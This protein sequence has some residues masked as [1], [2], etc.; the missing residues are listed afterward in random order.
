MRVAREGDQL[1]LRWTSPEKSTRAPDWPAAPS[2]VLVS[3]LEELQVSYRRELNGDWQREW[4]Q[5]GTPSLL[6]LQIKAS[7]RYWPELIMGL[8]E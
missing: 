8:R 5:A 1:V 7:G 3:D 6:K 4:D 2:R